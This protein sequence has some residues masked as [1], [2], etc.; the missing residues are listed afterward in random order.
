MTITIKQNSLYK[1]CVLYL[2]IP[3]LFFFMGWLKFGVGLFLSAL[4]LSASILFLYKVKDIIKNDNY[5]IVSK[6]YYITFIILFLFLLSTGNT[7]FVGSWGVDIPWRNAIYQDLIRQSWPVMY[8]YSHSML[9]YYMTF[10]LVPAALSFVLT[11]D[12]A[13]TF[14]SKLLPALTFMLY[15]SL[16]LWADIPDI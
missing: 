11:Y 6:E 3:I 7:G 8:E 9:C 16:S 10:W 14:T 15:T 12:S 5:V 4:L 1:G 2:V 13:A